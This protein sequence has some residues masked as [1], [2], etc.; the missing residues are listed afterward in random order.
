MLYKDMTTEEINK[1][2]MEIPEEQWWKHPELIKE[3]IKRWFKMC[4]G[5]GFTNEVKG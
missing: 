5:L 1:K 4:K 3:A 2:L